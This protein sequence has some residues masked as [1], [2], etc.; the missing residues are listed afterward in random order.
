VHFWRGHQLRSNAPAALAALVSVYGLLTHPADVVKHIQ[1][2]S[3]ML[4]PSTVK[5]LSEELQ[6]IVSSSSTSL[7]L[8]A[9]NGLS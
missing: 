3:G 9:S 8:G 4:P 2:L 6:Q 5:L 7:G 1:S